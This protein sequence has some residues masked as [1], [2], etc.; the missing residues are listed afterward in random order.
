MN[1]NKYSITFACYNAVEYTKLCINSLIK[2]GTPLDRV[3]V[4]DNASKDGTADYL[5]SLPL[6][7]RIFN[8]QNMGCGTAWNQGA[9]FHQ[10]E[11]TVIMNNDIITPQGWIENLI[12]A[13]EQLNLKVASPAMIEGKLDYDFDVFSLSAQKKMGLVSR[14]YTQ[15]AVCLAVHESVWHEVGYFQAVP[16]LLGFE[17]TLFFHE[18][19]KENISRAILGASWLHHFGSVT[20]SLMKQEKNLSLNQ[21]L[22]NR[23][24]YRLLNQSW[25][26]RKWRK[27]QRKKQQ[28][29]WHD[30]ELAQYGMTLHG[31]RKNNSFEWL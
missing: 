18:L 21:G 15:H 10:S 7:G 19:A 2:S 1:P 5:S 12:G 22:A 26:E 24:N 9:L 4:V 13:A 6:G 27:Y 8:R 25:L 30:Q 11:W 31:Q 14:K 29:R 17:D 23:Y 16:K 20:Q 28:N 3:V